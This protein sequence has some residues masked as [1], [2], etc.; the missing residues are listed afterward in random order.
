MQRSSH[1]DK[2]KRSPLKGFL[3]FLWLSLAALGGILLADWLA[4]PGWL[5]AVGCGLSV[6][7]LVLAKALP[8]SIAFTHILRKWTGADKRLP[9]VML[10]ALF[11]LAAWRYAVYQPKIIPGHI[12][13]FNDRGRVELT[14][15]LVEPPDIRD[16]T[17]NLTVRVET[18]RLPV[19]G[20]GEDAVQEM[21]GLVLVQTSPGG[22]WVYGDRLVIRGELQTPSES[23]DF[24]YRDYLARQRI[25]SLMT[26]AQVE[27]IGVDAGNPIRT[28]LYGLRRRGLDTLQV[29]FPSPESD[30]LA[31]IL[32]G[33]DEGLS[34]QLQEAFRRTGTTHIIA[35]SGFNMAILAGL[36]SGI[37]ARLFGR[38]WGAAAAILGISGYTVLVGAEAAVVRAAIMG[39]LGV[40]GGMFGRRQ[41]GLNSLGLAGLLMMFQNPNIPWDVGFQLSVA[42]TLGLVL[43]A[44]PLE[45]RLIALMAKRMPEERAQRWAGPVSEFF[46]FTIIAQWLTLPVMA[47]HFEG[48]SWLAILVNPL[49]LPVQSLVMILGGLAMLGG[50]LLPGLGWALVVV[51]QPFVSYTIRVVSWLGMLPVGEWQVPAFHPLWLI[52]YYGVLFFL[53]LF[54]KETRQKALRKVL[55]PQMG[56]LILFGLVILTWRHILSAP[57]G[58]LNLTLL[59]A[60]GTILIQS[61]GGRAVLIGAGSRPSELNESLG[62]MLPAGKGRMDALVVGSTYRDDLNALTGALDRFHPEMTLWHGDPEV[63]QAS[64]QVYARLLAEEVPMQV[65]E[66]G[67]TLTIEEGV[68]LRVLWTGDRGAM[69]WLEWKEFNALLPAGKVDECWLDVPAPPDVVLLPD[70]VDEELLALD[71]FTVW[72]T[73]AILLPMAEADLPL[74][75]EHPVLAA[76]ADYPV[77]NAVDHGWIRVSTDGESLWVTGER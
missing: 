49:I 2:P 24:S 44:Q 42:A 23:G 28:R 76:L 32:L 38:K 3:P 21:E 72:G 41:N 74:Q 70:G 15:V 50:M 69:F 35:I 77:V 59:D 55:T 18:M 17:I 22:D 64:R 67:Q 63:N 65:V 58:N 75:G 29:L 62:Q 25:L 37:T 8:K 54:P 53:T 36:F 73:Q 27:R 26:Y 48:I 34:P 14:G 68:M 12:A 57:D 45:E 30:L 61:P 7:T 43:Y 20:P 52:L 19:V 46:L 71:A 47:Y 16:K 40:F 66:S 13:Y 39:A 4:W 31:G 60:E 1:P 56:V 11:F 10:V 9:S 51:A 5:W 6:A 33:L